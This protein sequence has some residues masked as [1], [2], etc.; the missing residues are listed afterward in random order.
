MAPMIFANDLFDSQPR[1]RGCM[2][3]AAALWRSARC[4]VPHMAH[5]ERV[6][7]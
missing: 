3:L 7:L 6:E 1:P 4:P 5:R 2:N